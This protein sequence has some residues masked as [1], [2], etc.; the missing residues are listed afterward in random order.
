NTLSQGLPAVLND[1][2]SFLTE[3]IQDGRNATEFVLYSG[4]GSAMGHY[5]CQW[6]RSRGFPG[7]AQTYQMSLLFDTSLLCGEKVDLDME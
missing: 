1:F 6:A 3:A 4:L 7:E 2:H 5:T